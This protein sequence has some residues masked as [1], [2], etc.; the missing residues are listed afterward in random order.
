MGNKD[1]Q[2]EG[3]PLLKG[4]TPLLLGYPSVGHSQAKGSY[5]EASKGT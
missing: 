2:I 1:S 4:G 5:R 3:K